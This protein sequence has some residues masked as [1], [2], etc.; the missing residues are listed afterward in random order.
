MS[1]MPSDARFTGSL[2]WWPHRG[3]VP[4]EDPESGAFSYIGPAP[5]LEVS[6]TVGEQRNPQAFLVQFGGDRELRT[7][8]HPV[9]Q[10]QIFVAGEGTFFRHDVTPG[11]VHYVDPYVPYGPLMS[12]ARGIAFLTLR[13][14]ADSGAYFVPEN[15]ER[16]ASSR[17]E[18]GAVPR[19][20]KQVDLSVG[21]EEPGR[22][23]RDHVCD[24]DG[25][26]ISAAGVTPDVPLEVPPIEGEGAYLVVLSGTVTGPDAVAGTET[27]YGPGSLTFRLPGSEAGEPVRSGPAGARIA[28]VQ[29]PD[30]ISRNH[31]RLAM[32]GPGQ[33]A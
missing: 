9:A 29:L 1:A 24:E 10:F 3:A 11:V 8:Y 21:S 31:D 4:F 26:R 30:L 20:N 28:L 23:W 19:R 12:G 32:A 16:L 15:R 25:L 14:I 27:T 33:R 22:G 2:T 18:R 17:S 6:P 5:G 7:H 13:G